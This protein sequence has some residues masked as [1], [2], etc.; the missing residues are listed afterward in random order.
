VDLPDPPS[1][2]SNV[3]DF[4]KIRYQAAVDAALAEAAHSDELRKAQFDAEHA[5]AKSVHDARL[6]VAK[7]AIDRGH[8]GAEFVRNAAAAIVTLYT[9][10][11]GVAFA[12]G[13]DATPLPSRG[14]VPAVFLGIAVATASAYVGLLRRDPDTPPPVPH[15]TLSIFQER[16]LRS[17]VELASKIALSRAYFL[18]ASV[19]SLGFGVLLLPAPFIALANWVVFVLAAVALLA[20]LLLPV[21]TTRS[22]AP[23]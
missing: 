17:F 22:R 10:I 15:S 1:Q 21:A 16:R 23:R 12:T 20:A 4:L 8:R 9:G 19:I 13:E 2:A 5:L 11:L 18:H 7:A 3:D 6:E 14:V